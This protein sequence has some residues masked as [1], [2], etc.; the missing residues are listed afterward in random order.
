MD[1]QYTQNNHKLLTE[2]EFQEGKV[3]PL[4]SYAKGNI[5]LWAN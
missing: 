3:Q 2:D 1:S 4:G 5:G